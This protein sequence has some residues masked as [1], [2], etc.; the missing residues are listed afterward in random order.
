MEMALGFG[1]GGGRSDLDAVSQSVVSM[2]LSGGA[3][4]VGS[5]ATVPPSAAVPA[6][7]TRT[8][9]RSLREVA[10]ARLNEGGVVA[11]VG[12]TRTLGPGGTASAAPAAAATRVQRQDGVTVAAAAAHAPGPARAAASVPGGGERSL[13]RSHS[14]SHV[15]PQQQQRTPS[16]AI[17]LL[18]TSLGDGA[19]V[20]SMAVVGRSSP[21]TYYGGGGWSESLHGYDRDDSSLFS[22]PGYGPTFGFGGAGGM[23]STEQLLAQMEMLGGARSLLSSLSAASLGSGANTGA[24]AAA[25]K[26]KQRRRVANVP[27]PAPP[28]STPAPAIVQ[29]TTAQTSASASASAA[30]SGSSTSASSASGAVLRIAGSGIV[31][32]GGATA[33]AAAAPSMGATASTAVTAVA[34]STSTSTSTS[35]ASTSGNAPWTCKGCGVAV[36]A[37]LSSCTRCFASRPTPATA[38]AAVDDDC[39]ICFDGPKD[40]L[41]APCGHVCCCIACANALLEKEEKCPVCRRF[42][43]SAFKVFNV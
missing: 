42:I 5:G 8:L 3:G 17:L 35:A 12:D 1:G 39:V 34:S 7:S 28:S 15:Q 43:E 30:A 21:P 6:G 20:H 27:E 16:H 13:P 25:D 10:Q 26:P 18:P 23:T 24:A 4:A 38:A 22:F 33:A 41:L 11:R 31:S 2:M 14:Q 29:G 19:V 40:T 37:L 36:D 32:G 9:V